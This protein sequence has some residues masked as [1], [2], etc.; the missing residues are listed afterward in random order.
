MGDVGQTQSHARTYGT[1]DIV[2]VD[3]R[4]KAGRQMV[5]LPSILVTARLAV[6]VSGSPLERQPAARRRRRFAWPIG[7]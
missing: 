5:S 2:F 3:R 4:V 1:D 7:P 6:R